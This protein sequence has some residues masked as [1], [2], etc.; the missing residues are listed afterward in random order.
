MSK[1]FFSCFINS[2]SLSHPLI[3]VLNSTLIVIVIIVTLAHSPFPQTRHF[4]RQAFEK[5]EGLILAKLF[6]LGHHLWNR[7]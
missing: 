7:P 6:G 4:P 3:F 2:L 5:L 1:P